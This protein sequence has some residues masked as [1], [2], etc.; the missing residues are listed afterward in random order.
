LGKAIL[1]INTQL[2]YAKYGLSLT[3]PVPVHAVQRSVLPG[4]KWM[5]TKSELVELVYALHETGAFGAASLKNTF[6]VICKIFD[7]D[8]KNYHRLFW[9]I[10]GRKGN[11]TPFLKSIMQ[12][13]E[14]KCIQMDD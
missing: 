3:V 1:L 2:E 12:N 14:N 9:D 7:C 10:K 8:I 5:G 4:L 13:L 6:T 11:R